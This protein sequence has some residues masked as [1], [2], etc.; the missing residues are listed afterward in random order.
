MESVGSVCAAV[1][2]ANADKAVVS[3]PRTKPVERRISRRPGT[4]RTGAVPG[5][6][7]GRR[8]DPGQAEPKD[9]DCREAPSPSLF[10]LVSGGGGGGGE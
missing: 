1:S 10:P 4:S 3:N 2:A 8:P 7:P 9:E 5:R 6:S